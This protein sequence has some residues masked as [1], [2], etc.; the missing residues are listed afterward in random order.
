MNRFVALCLL[1]GFVFGV[2]LALDVYQRKIEHPGKETIIFASMW[3]PGEPTQIGYD[4]LFR[5]FEAEFPQY[6][7]EPRYDG[8]Y[9]LP[10]I[11][12][13]LLTGSDIPDILNTD[14][15]S[16]KIIVEEGYADTLD[17]VLQGTP[18]PDDPSKKLAG[19]YLPKILER[20]RYEQ[21]E[22]GK[23]E[24]GTYLAPTG[25]WSD[26]IFYNRVHYEALNLPVP[27]T[28]TQLV[29]NCT[30]LKAAGYVPFAA[31]KDDYSEFWP[32]LMMNRALP[33]ETLKQTILTGKPRFDA[34][35][36]YR[37]VFQGIRDLHQPGWYME[38]WRGSPWPAAQR[39]WA[40]GEAT[41]MICGTYLIKEILEYKPDAEVFRAGCFPVPSI[42]TILDDDA[43]LPRGDATGVTA[44]IAGHALLKGGRCR[45][46][47]VKLLG[48]LARRESAAVIAEYGKEIPPVIGT[49]FPKELKDIR[50]D[51][52]K[53]ERIFDTGYYVYAPKWAKFVWKDLWIS[54]FLNE[55]PDQSGYMTVDEFLKTLQEKTEAYVA[56]GGEAGIR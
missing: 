41:H 32:G 2:T 44:A 38:G 18:H 46:G 8:R 4:K 51:F 15:V 21:V 55:S 13:R 48:F 37:A 42:D 33:Q 49:E 23:F 9:V 16:L 19:A 7:V 17:A 30:K 20:C 43:P 1:V 45:E 14:F 24:G 35:P 29:D 50:E 5:Q 25:V 34:D 10:A 28:W 6:R 27:R 39:R 12:P 56:A 47:A 22:G 53:A 3:A 36:R 52:A 31:D 26:F 54:F 40:K 11:R